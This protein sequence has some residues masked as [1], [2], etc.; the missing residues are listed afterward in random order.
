MTKKNRGIEALL[1]IALSLSVG[2]SQ[3]RQ[4]PQ[5]SRRTTGTPVAPFLLQAKSYEESPYV[6]KVVFRNGLTVLVDEYKTQ[7]VVSMQAYL[8]AGT[9]NEP[10]RNLG[11]AQLLAALITAKAADKSL[12]TLR[13]NVQS[14]GGRLAVSTDCQ[15]TELEIIAPSS[16]WK[17][18]LSVQAEALFSL[19]LS[20]NDLNLRAS[21]VQAR[22]RRVLDNEDEFARERLLELAFDQ[23]RMGR[24]DA[25][26]HANLKDI[27]AEAVTSFYKAVYTPAN[28][29]LVIS[30]DISA[31]EVLNELAT[32]YNKPASSVQKPVSIALQESQRGFRYGAIKGNAAIAR[33]LFGFHT[34]SE[35]SADYAPVEIL[36]AILGVGDG[37]ALS[38]RLRDQKK[39]ILSQDMQ[40]ITRP[41]FGFL[42]FQ[43]NVLP[44]D[45]DRSEIA[46]LT[47]IELLKREEPNDAEM[48]RALAQL[49][50]S[51]WRSLETVTG[52]AHA[53]A[54]FEMLGDWK[55]MNR[56]LSELRQVKRSDVKRVANK[57]LVLDNCTLLEVL[58]QS[59]E[60]RNLTTEGVRRT[61]EGLL[62]P[63][64]DQ[65][66]AQRERE[67]VP[68]IKFPEG[69][70]VFKF[71]E[72]R[73]PFQMASVLRGPDIFIREDHTNPI[74]D[75]GLYFP[76]G[77]PGE[78][79]ENAGITRLMTHLMLRG[80]KDKPAAQFYRQFEIY[81]GQ[82]RPV[83]ADDY[84]GVYFSVLSKNF[85]PAFNL[86][87][88][89][90][91]AP[92]FE[93][94]LIDREKDLQKTEMLVQKNSASYA[95]QLINQAL[96]KGSPYAL[97]W[98]GTEESLAAISQE[99]LQSWYD[100]Y[101]K[102]RKPVVVSIGD[103]KGTSLASNFVQHFSGSRIQETKIEGRA[104]KPVEK[105]ESIVTKW[106]KN[107][108]LIVVGF[109]AP[110]VDD[111]DRYAATVIE[112]YSGGLGKFSQEITEQ[113][114][115][116]EEISADYVP[117]LRG[118]SLVFSTTPAGE[119]EETVLTALLGQIQKVTTAT[120]LYRDFRAAINE[121]VGNYWIKS[122]D[123]F[124]Q[125]GGIVEELL[126]GKGIE[127]YENFVSDVQQVKEE[128]FKEVAERIFRT[129]KAVIICMQ[130]K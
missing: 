50:R 13:Q 51:Y 45:I 82:V 5:T 85:D 56:Y 23:P 125:I 127:G 66:Q 44:A 120:L 130:R 12:G 122:Q 42:T 89:M 36:K 116:A 69:T 63:A 4:V 26:T 83:V 58:P 91:K 87:Q 92:G 38:A 22:A 113:Q 76:G 57:Y 29:L 17:K 98:Y 2:Y 21:V 107:A 49:E 84:F 101:V 88:E 64:T 108:D 97:D 14:L 7:P 106:D 25:V 110:A 20:Q 15:N 123:R 10:A 118:G 81:G 78:K 28:T 75:V 109:Q 34:V 16:Q 96:F 65:E 111:E 126:A 129:D 40:Q 114:G 67:V 55:R 68:A 104:V 121:A 93:K 47:E 8:R 115:A 71:S 102:N 37:S 117:L 43:L 61:L 11:L 80:T 33:L 18:A 35:R 94:D 32:I 24:W 124:L 62:Q 72:M 1:V 27:P 99:A 70:G 54:R 39:L 30:G 128:D 41:D 31:S 112:N 79:K 74:I 53:L 59:A 105:G 52:R 100:T 48:E 73:Y 60:E 119:S 19:S 90:I 6:T 86:L 46:A 3:T 77:R 9:L 103:T 95:R